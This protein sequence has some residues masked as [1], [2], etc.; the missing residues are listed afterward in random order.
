M[1]GVMIDLLQGRVG[2]S[3]LVDH[4]LVPSLDHKAQ[5]LQSLENLDRELLIPYE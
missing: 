3:V 5:V 1:S 4:Y 2:K